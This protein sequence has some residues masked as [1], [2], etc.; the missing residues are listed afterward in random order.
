VFHEGSKRNTAC[1]GRFEAC[2]VNEVDGARLGHEVDGG[3][4]DDE[5]G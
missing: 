3:Y 2:I 1:D 4:E 5:E